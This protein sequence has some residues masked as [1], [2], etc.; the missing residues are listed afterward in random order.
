MN[1]YFTDKI[2]DVQITSFV[3]KNKK[4]YKHIQ[5]MFNCVLPKKIDIYVFNTECD[6][7]GNTLSYAN[8][9][10]CTIHTKLEHTYGH[11]LAHVIYWYLHPNIIK[12]RFIDEG[13]ATYFD[14]ENYFKVCDIDSF[15]L[16]NTGKLT[17]RMYN[18]L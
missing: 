17:L 12:T 4:A 15:D 6:N 13:I 1:F 7:L 10:L 8:P 14:R 3:N 18:K 16:G 9:A 2:S 5:S 11:E